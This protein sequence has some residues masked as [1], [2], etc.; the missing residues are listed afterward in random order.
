MAMPPMPPQGSAPAPQEGAPQDGGAPDE[1]AVD[2]PSD[3]K[4]LLIEVHTGLSKIL[5][6]AQKAG[7]PTSVLKQLQTSLDSFR[8]AVEEM[9]GGGGQQQHQVAPSEVGGNPNAVPM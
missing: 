1:G 5:Q 4:Q 7:A 9:I 3:P 6:A 2:Q 8:G